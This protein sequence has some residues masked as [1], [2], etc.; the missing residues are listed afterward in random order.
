MGKERRTIRRARLA[1]KED[2][3]RRSFSSHPESCE[4]MD[5]VERIHVADPCKVKAIAEAT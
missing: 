1:N 3:L 4:G 2:V 5:E